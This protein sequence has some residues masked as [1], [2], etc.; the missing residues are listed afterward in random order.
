MKK[1]RDLDRATR[2]ALLRGEP[3]ADPEVDRVARAYAEKALNRSTVRRFWITFPFGL[4]L[5][6][7][8]GYGAIATDLPISLWFLVIAVAGI[9]YVV[10]AVRRQLAQVRILNV[11]NGAPRESVAPGLP[12]RLEVGM[13]TGGV[14]RTLLP[15]FGIAAILLVPGLV[16]SMPVLIGIALIPMGLVLAYAGYLLSWSLPDHPQFVLD[17]DG[18]HTPRYGLRVRWDAIRELRLLPLG[19]SSGDTRRVLA[20]VLHDNRTYLDHIPRWAAFL[21][22]M[23]TKTYLSPMT[24]MDGLVDKPIEQIA[25]TAAALSGLP[26]SS[27][28]TNSP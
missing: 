1:W 23:N 6:A 17:A 15:H 4:V 27:V 28:A 7:S 14:V 20:F 18:V 5:G 12:E 19:A 21:A 8:L 24:T 11:S 26:V 13:P 9:G 22:S 10:I 25:A 3:A 16:L 2:K